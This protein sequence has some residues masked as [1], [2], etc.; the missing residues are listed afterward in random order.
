MKATS[1]AHLRRRER[2]RWQNGPVDSALHPKGETP[3]AV[4]GTWAQRTPVA[5]RVCRDVYDTTCCRVCAVPEASGTSRSVG[6]FADV[7]SL[8]EQYPAVD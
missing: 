2:H 4:E 8:P 7:V 3:L 5:P 6:L 1:G